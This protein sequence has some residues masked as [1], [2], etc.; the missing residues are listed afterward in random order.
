MSLPGSIS[1]I[2]AFRHSF[3]RTSDGELPHK[4]PKLPE[5]YP[6][7]ADPFKL[8]CQGPREW[9]YNPKKHM[10]LPYKRYTFSKRPAFVVRSDLSRMLEALVTRYIP[11][12]GSITAGDALA[13]ISSDTSWIARQ[14]CEDYRARAS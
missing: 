4:Q 2:L 3:L 13:Q 1:K 5:E 8:Y 6:W 14:W 11:W 7:F 10:S 9:R 12:C